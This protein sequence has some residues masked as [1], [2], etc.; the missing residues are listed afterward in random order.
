MHADGE[1]GR[2]ARDRAIQHVD[3]K[4]HQLV[5]IVALAFCK[6]ADV[7]VAQERERH[8]VELQ[9]AATGVI[10]FL[11]LLLENRDHVVPICVVVRIDLAVDRFLE[12]AEMHVRRR[13]HRHLDAVMRDGLQEL[14]IVGDNRL[15]APDLLRG[16]RRR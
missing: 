6:L 10:D 14:E 9:I 12:L 4:I 3:I 16:D 7:L 1:I 11:H 13:R 8:L 2:A 15:L 5:G